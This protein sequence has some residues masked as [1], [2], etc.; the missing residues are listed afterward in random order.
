MS[1]R[2]LYSNDIYIMKLF[3]LNKNLTEKNVN[4]FT[5]KQIDNNCFFFLFYLNVD[6]L[7]L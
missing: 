3:S 2:S 5:E 6:L 7:N 4:I 1:N